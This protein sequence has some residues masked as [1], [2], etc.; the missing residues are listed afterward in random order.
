MSGDD[1]KEGCSDCRAGPGRDSLT[2]TYVPCEL[3]QTVAISRYAS[4]FIHYSSHEMYWTS[5]SFPLSHVVQSQEVLSSLPNPNLHCTRPVVASLIPRLRESETRKR[6]GGD[7]SF[8]PHWSP[9]WL[10][11]R[12]VAGAFVLLPRGKFTEPMLEMA[13]WIVGMEGRGGDP[14]VCNLKEEEEERDDRRRRR[15]IALPLFP[16]GKCH[17]SSLS[18]Q[19]GMNVKKPANNLDGMWSR[20][21]PRPRGSTIHL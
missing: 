19:R 2:L 10:G 8:P 4:N 21:R 5:L 14:H 7:D 3:A 18:A 11:M 9:G 6:G 17:A 12:H 1:N 20:P 16:F 13:S 15:C